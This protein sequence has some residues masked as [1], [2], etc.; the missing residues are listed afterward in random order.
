LTNISFEQ[1]VFNAG[2]FESQADFTFT[3]TPAVDL[4]YRLFRTADRHVR[5]PE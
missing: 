2:L 3:V 4:R 1:N 5:G